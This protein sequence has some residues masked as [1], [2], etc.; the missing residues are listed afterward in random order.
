VDPFNPKGSKKSG[1]E[2]LIQE[3]LINFLKIRDWYVKVTHGNI[4]QFGFP[5]LYCCHLKF[6]T[7][8][9]E[10]KNPTKYSFTAAQLETFPHFAAK[11]VG[12][13]VLTAATEYEY[14]KLFGPA[15]WHTFLMR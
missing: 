4:Y 14:R 10:V 2:A 13:W 12:V 9:I 1:P 15:N 6:G 3:A 7:R 8:W 5:D 11:G